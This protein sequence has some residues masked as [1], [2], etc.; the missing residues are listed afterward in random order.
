MIWL[1]LA[2]RNVLAYRRR[3]LIAMGA[4][5]FACLALTVFAGFVNE[6]REGMKLSFIHLQG[7]GHLQISGKGGFGDFAETALQFGLT[8]TQRNAIEA[9]GDKTPEVRR[10]VPRLEFGGM[11]SSGPRTLPYSGVAID[12]SLEKAAFGM[13]GQVKS[14]KPLDRR[15]PD[16]GVILGVEMARQLG[17]KPGD[18]VT[19]MAPTVLGGLNAMDMTVVGLRE[20]GSTQGDSYYLQ[21][22]LPTI[23]KLLIT[24][25]I[26][27]LAVVLDDKADVAAV[28][29]RLLTAA[30]GLDARTWLQLQP[31]YKQVM[32]MYETAFTVFGT[33]ILIVTLMG[34]GVLILTSVLERAR[35]IG[36][37]RSLGIAG[38]QVRSTFVFEGMLLCIAGLLVGAIGGGLA[39]WGINALHLTVPPPPGSTR[40]FPLR[41]LWDWG[42]LGEV[43][44]LVLILGLAAS[45]LTSGRVARLKVVQALGAL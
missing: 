8:P 6:T 3:S 42:A 37:M 19:V 40:G 44:I 18:Y 1:K 5:A 28:E 30:P 15:A 4:I 41:L 29:A 24:D 11:V 43:A 10:M 20:T 33:L 36:V 2:A 25:K 12:P 9:L 32:G 45:W 13:G 26:S 21:A 14:G 7:T 39:T 34:V 16:D 17:V 27:K 23:Q 31:I 35:E 22:K 38:G